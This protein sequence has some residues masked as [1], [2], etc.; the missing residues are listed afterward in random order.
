MTGLFLSML[1]T[2]ASVSLIVI[3]LYFIVILRMQ[4]KAGD[5]SCQ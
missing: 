3:G 4:K 5:G 2:S 1:E